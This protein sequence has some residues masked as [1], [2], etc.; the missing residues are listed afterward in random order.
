VALLAVGLSFKD[1]IYPLIT[2]TPSKDPTKP[3][4]APAES[5]FEDEFANPTRT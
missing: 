4:D 1:K 5:K 2:G 3:K